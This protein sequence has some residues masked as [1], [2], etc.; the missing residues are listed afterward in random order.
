MDTPP[1]CSPL[2]SRDGSRVAWGNSDGTVTVCYPEAIRGQLD[3]VGL[4]W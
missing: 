3:R 2:F 1:S 4:G